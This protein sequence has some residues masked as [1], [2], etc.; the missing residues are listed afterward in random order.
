MKVPSKLKLKIRIEGGK[1]ST[2]LPAVREVIKHYEG[3]LIHVTFQKI[4]NT[5][6]RPQNKY[7]WAVI[8]AIFKNAIR[9]EW[10]EL[11]SADDVHLFLKENCN[12][13]ERYNEST[14]MVVRTVKST[15]ENSTVEQEDFHQRCRNLASEFFNVNIPLPN[16]ETNIEY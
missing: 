2:N 9:E 6:T 16:E 3:Q 1:F 7:Y 10:G 13:T 12:Y 5:R 8:V 4:K 15:T 11:W 14:G